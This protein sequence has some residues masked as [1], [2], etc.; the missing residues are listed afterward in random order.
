[1]EFD[2]YTIDLNADCKCGCMDAGRFHKI[3]RFPN[4]LG[5][6]VVGGRKRPGTEER[7]Y[8]VML[9][10]FT[11]PESYENVEIDGFDS[12]VVDCDDWSQAV[13]VLERLRS[14]RLY[15]GIAEGLPSQ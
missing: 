4:D 1:M 12:K 15:R 13:G 8:R 14:L 3:Y 5:A 7:S 10:R 2:E 11:G 9:L 6:S